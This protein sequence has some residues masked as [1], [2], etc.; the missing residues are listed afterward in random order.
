MKIV[1]T[2]LPLIIGI[3]S[4]GLYLLSIFIVK[5]NANSAQY[6]FL[7][8]SFYL[9]LLGNFF[10]R[11]NWLKALLFVLGVF[12]LVMSFGNSGFVCFDVCPTTFDVKL[13][14]EVNFFSLF[15]FAISLILTTFQNLKIRIG[16]LA[17]TSIVFIW[18][19]SL[20]M[21]FSP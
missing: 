9:V 17:L 20:V 11:I 3:L 21:R 12:Y 7:F 4:F 8:A 10:I 1:K 14:L 16:L 6:F 2:Y 18:I 15:L 5:P 19:L 13:Y